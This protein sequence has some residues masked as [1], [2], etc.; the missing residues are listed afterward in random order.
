S[1]T[2]PAAPV[3][4][5]N[6]TTGPWYFWCGLQPYGGG[7]V[8]P[9]LGWRESEPNALNPNPPFPKVWEMNLW[10]VP[11][12]GANQPPPQTAQMSSGIW[13]D[14]GALIASTVIWETESSEWVQTANVLSGAAAG[15]PVSMITPASFLSDGDNHTFYALCLPRRLYGTHAGQYWHFNVTLTNV[16]FRAITSVGV[17]SLCASAAD[18]SNDQGGIAFAGFKM[19]DPETCYWE[20][21][22]LM[23]PGLSELR[24][25]Q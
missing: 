2:V 9:V 19:V 3:V 4:P 16:V 10:A 15:Q 24:K 25:N 18:Y 5:L 1:I 12:N 23:P 14:E 17:Q 11:W 22:T 13:A 21:I 6:L 8:Q 7:V 20:S